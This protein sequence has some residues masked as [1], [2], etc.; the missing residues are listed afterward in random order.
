MAVNNNSTVN[1][2]FN[3][4][5]IKN[6][7]VGGLSSGLDTDSIVEA[8]LSSTRSK[9]ALQQQNKQLLQW[10]MS[11]YRSTA[12][13]IS[14]FQSKYFSFANAASQ[15]LLSTGFYSSFK[16][17]S[18]SD[19]ISVATTSSTGIADFSVKEVNQLATAQ[20]IEAGESLSAKLQSSIDWTSFEA[21][22]FTGQTL[23][24]DVDGAVK[25]LRLDSLS[26]AASKADFQAKLQDLLDDAYGLK[27]NV[28]I[29]GKK[30]KDMT[31][32]EKL[33]MTGAQW[34]SVRVVTAK[35]D[36][37]DKL[38][39]DAGTNRVSVAKTNDVIGLKQGQTNRVDI[40]TK[41][42]DIA[43]L[44]AVLAG[45]M[46]TFKING[47]EITVNSSDTIAGLMSAVNSSAANVRMSYSAITDSF[48]MTSKV[49]GAGN[50][51]QMED[52]YGNL[53]S[54]IFGAESSGSVVSRKF[55]HES[56]IVSLDSYDSMTG[57]QKLNFVN[58]FNGRAFTM[59]ING[60]SRELTL[61]FSSD[62]DARAALE[63]GNPPTIESLVGV[64]NNAIHSAFYTSAEGAEFKILDVG[65]GKQLELTVNAGVAV[66]ME[67][68]KTSTTRDLLGQLGFAESNRT[69]VIDFSS[70]GGGLDRKATEMGFA[71]G[72]TFTVQAKDGTQSSITVDANTTVQGLLDTLSVNGVNISVENFAKSGEA[73]D[74]RLTLKVDDGASVE[75]VGN[76]GL[77]SRLFGISSYEK[78]AQ[79]YDSRMKLGTN[80]EITMED[81]TVVVNANNTFDLYGA[82]I[83]I[84]AV[85]AAGDAP[86]RV[87]VASNPDELVD[88]I[89]TFVD[90]YN[91]MIGALNA[92]I[93]EESK[94]GYSPLSD[95]QK[96]DMTT[97]EIEKWEIEAKKGILRSDS[98]LRGI[99]DQLRGAF[100]DK[101]QSVGLA[102]YDLGI[103]TQNLNGNMMNN[104]KIELNRDKLR[105][106]VEK[107][108]DAV[109][110]AFTDEKNGIANKLNEVMRR[111]VDTSSLPE[112]RGSLVRMAGTDLM[113]ANNTSNLGSRINSIDSRLAS[114]RTLMETQYNRYWKQF[115]NLE[116]ALSKL[117]S[118]ASLFFPA[119]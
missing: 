37:D 108:P 96:K 91:V 23:S 8:M 42:S 90:E 10:K 17:T 41:L 16:A 38:V 79:N 53:L 68:N 106:A 25:V 52:V 14:S 54:S 11:A 56:G 57:E 80:A 83:T 95:E 87:S 88:R 66:S 22:D 27:Q 18:T 73:A 86:I 100:Y 94:Y 67:N 45:D 47:E 3:S 117:N 114:L 34:D 33:A 29:N 55:A 7:G 76:D 119:Q 60:V 72:E 1:N 92:L 116:V 9:I 31:S 69:N 59:T 89:A 84:N 112:K 115:S 48:T 15:N 63:G 20:S 40:N 36:G 82:R 64:L 5:G 32:D 85:S 97:D 109:R 19:K 24:L 21:A 99:V 26:G 35:L 78:A 58:N 103:T 30:F 65:A 75:D 105:A 12:K 49:T 43:N 4:L 6:K 113:T 70:A 13:V 77:L 102:A 98:T 118:Q 111:A 93:Y 2:I 107:N 110:I 104:G 28:E 46:Y 51:L 74:Y 50:N 39:L 61:D 81:G 71:V 62:A 44:G 101:I